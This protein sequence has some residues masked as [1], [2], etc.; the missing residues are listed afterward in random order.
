VPASSTTEVADRVLVGG[1][2]YTNLRDLSAGPELV[3]RLRRETWPAGVDVEDLSAGAIH[4]VHELQA[5]PPY[6]AA[7]LVAAVARGRRPGTIHERR[8]HHP[9]LAPG[10]VQERVGEALTGVISLDALLAVLGHFGVLPA[11]TT[12]FEI[13]PRDTAWGEPLS[14]PVAGALTA[15]EARVREAAL[16]AVGEPA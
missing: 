3:A 9:S 1:V 6:R 7:V 10:E 12:V 11:A 5:R 13:E 14:A 15:L 8:W 4:L 2:G 16:R